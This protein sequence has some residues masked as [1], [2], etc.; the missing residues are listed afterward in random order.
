MI[1]PGRLRSARQN[2]GPDGSGMVGPH[3]AS[4]RRSVFAPAAM[5]ARIPAPVLNCDPGRPVDGDGG[6]LVLLAHLEV[7]LEPAAA[8]DHATT[9]TDIEHALA[10][11]HA[12]AGH[13]A[14]VEQQLGQLGLVEHG[15]ARVVETL[16]QTDRE[17]VAHRVHLPAA[18]QAHDPAHQDLGHGHRAAPGAHAQADLAEVGLG[19]DQVGG[20]LGVLRVQPLELV[21]EEARVHRHRLDAA[22]R[23]PAAGC[24]G[25]V[26]GVL[27]HPREAHG[28]PL[29]DEVH[30]LGPA[31][32][33]GVASGS[34]HDVADDGG[35]VELGQ[36]GVVGLSG[37]TQRVVAGDPDPAAAARGRPAEVRALLDQQGVQAV[38]GGRQRGRHPGAA[39]A[40]HDHVHL[41]RQRPAHGAKL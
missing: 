37:V 34:R 11:P 4:S 18:E 15:D 36:L 1:E 30:D 7:L 20:R 10:L 35:E 27:R 29:A 22:A 3:Q 23:G 31:V 41:V 33:V 28:R 25:V 16:A 24:L 13:P 38:R 17:G 12:Y 19:D 6:G 21:A 32:D 2:H 39:G 14:V 9:R 8:Q 26:V 5:P 40:D